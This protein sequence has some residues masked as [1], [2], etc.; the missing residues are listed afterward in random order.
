[1]E[2][3][4]HGGGVFELVIDGV[5]V[6][7]ERIQRRHLDTCTEA[8]PARLQPG[9]VGVPGTAHDQIEQSGAYGYASALVASGI[10]HAGELV[11][12]TAAQVDGLGRHVMPDVFIDAQAGD[13]GE[14]GLVVGCGLEDRLDGPPQRIP[15]ATELSGQTLDR[16]EIPRTISLVSSTLVTN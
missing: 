5:L 12:A 2:G 8:F 14:A 10:Y 6:A 1:M 9:L 11:R 16:A 13:A 3:I 7:M 4:E 15:G